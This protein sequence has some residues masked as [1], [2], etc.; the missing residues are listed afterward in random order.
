MS[1]EKKTLDF[2][3]QAIADGL[4]ELG[5]GV[6]VP[7]EKGEMK[8]GPECHEVYTIAEKLNKLIESWPVVFSRANDNKS[9]WWPQNPGRD[10]NVKARLAFIEEIEK[11][12]CKHES[13]VFINT[14]HWTQYTLDAYN[15][16]C[17]HCGVQLK[18]KWEAVNE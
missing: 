15:I 3:T 17:K 10:I 9:A 11:Q 4:N 12:P 1:E 7:N 13:Q 18:I 2:F 14:A 6:D 8:F 5:Y 16:K